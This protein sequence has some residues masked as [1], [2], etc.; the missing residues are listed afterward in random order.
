MSRN[1]S[2]IL[3]IF[4]SLALT[5]F[6]TLKA[7]ASAP[8]QIEPVCEDIY[9]VQEGDWLSKIA[10]KYYGDSLAYD[11]LVTAANANANDNYTNITN[12]DI[13]EPGW[14]ICIA[15]AETQ[16]APKD[17]EPA[18]TTSPLDAFEHTP[19]F[20]LI[21]KVWAWER[22]EP[23]GNAIEEI[24]VPTPENYLLYFE[25]DGTFYAKMD[26]HGSTG[27]YATEQRG[28]SYSIYMEAGPTTMIFCGED[29]LDIQMSQMFGP[30]QNYQYEENGETLKFIWAAGG[31]IDYYRHLNDAAPPVSK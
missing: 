20:N 30:A 18:A 12:P 11:R 14:V 31:P 15:P 25:E 3:L 24:I 28:A 16:T 4:L 26:C 22:R 23:N 5:S 2:L 19:D 17:T 7:S 1:N 13:I 8:A 9:T 10:Q 29:S 27:R 21:N 6:L